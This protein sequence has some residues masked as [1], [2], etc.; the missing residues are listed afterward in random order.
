MSPLLILS[1]SCCVRIDRIGFDSSIV[2]KRRGSDETRSICRTSKDYQEGKDAKR[3]ALHDSEPAEW[4][5][6]S[7]TLPPAAESSQARKIRDLLGKRDIVEESG[8]AYVV[9]KFINCCIS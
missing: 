5:A 1:S 4:K 6:L 3:A 8:F 2:I 9:G 7:R